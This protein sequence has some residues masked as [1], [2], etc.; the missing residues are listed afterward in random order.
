MALGWFKTT[1][2][3]A[4][5][6]CAGILVPVVA[7]S[8][9]L[10]PSATP[11]ATATPL[12]NDS[13]RWFEFDTLATALRYRL[14]RN[15][16]GVTIGNA[17]QYQLAARGHLKFDKKGKY[18][19][20]AGLFA[21]P[22]FTAGWNNTG[23]GTGNLQTNLYLKQLNFDAKP[24][25]GLE[26]QFGG[27]GL[28][29]GE[30]TEITGYDNDAYLTGERVAL[31]KPKKLYFDEISVA[32][33]FIGDLNRPSVFI[34]FKHL[35]KSNYHQF[36]VRKQVNKYVSYSAD[37]TFESGRDSLHEAVKLRIPGSHLLDT[38]IF[39]NYE[40]IDPVPG[41][42]FGLYGEKTLHKKFSLGGG[43]ARIDRP[44]LNADRFPP[45]NRI[46][47]S[48]VWKPNR[49]FTVSSFLFQGVGRLPSPTSHRTRFDLI[50]GFNILE[51]LRHYK[52]Y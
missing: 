15:A 50:F 41:Y 24:V 31:R 21:G 1:V 8:G 16:R 10:A 38:V 12:Q 13:K 52:L 36:L 17:L 23:L 44:M 20:N 42:G 30:N 9:Q 19:V 28:N 34:R 45:G 4:L 29:N 6:A 35:K 14:I 48:V 51:A 49:E 5:Y 22:N 11:A 18:T 27:L 37:Y 46:Y 47:G 3:A 40:R 25:T 32:N 26:F 39:E 43:F 33:G 2:I 7:V